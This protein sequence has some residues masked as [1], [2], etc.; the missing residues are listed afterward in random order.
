MPHTS[1]KTGAKVLLYSARMQRT[2]V[3]TITRNIGTD[4]FTYRLPNKERFTIYYGS[5]PIKLATSLEI[6]Q[7]R[8][9]GSIF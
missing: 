6:A 5:S 3:A 2:V 7:E 1:F 9:F 4:A 8:L